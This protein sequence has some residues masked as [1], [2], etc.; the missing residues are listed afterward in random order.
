VGL[1]RADDATV[2]QYARDNGLTILTKD[3]DFNQIALLSGGSP[4]VVWLRIGN[5]TTDQVL[6]LVRRHAAE[7]AAFVDGAEEAL[8]IVGEWEAD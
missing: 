8:L 5:C 7:I 4:K 6:E 2:W 3:S 1:A